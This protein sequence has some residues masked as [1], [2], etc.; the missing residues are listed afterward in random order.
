MLKPSDRWNWYYNET[1]KA[2]MLNLGQDDMVFNV[3]IAKKMLV[4]TAFEANEFSIDDANSYHT[5]C[6]QVNLLPISD[7]RKSELALNGVA[8]RR[9]HKPVQPKSWFFSS[10]GGD[11][12][13][14][15][16]EIVH[17]RNCYND[18]LFMV[19]EVGETASMCL[20][21]SLKDFSLTESKILQFGEPIK[22]MHDRFAKAYLQTQVDNFAMVG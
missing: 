13:P 12:T 20:S 18:G 5:F 19:V 22:V 21:V 17:L 3:N 11:F 7:P 15:E 2:L 1:E 14:V 6:E 10:Q 16:G 4:N 8:A 9:F